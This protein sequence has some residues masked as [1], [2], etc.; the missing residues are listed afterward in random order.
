M[1]CDVEKL[2]M[3]ADG[4][5]S[6]PEAASVRAHLESCT[7]CRDE[8]AAIELMRTQLAALPAPEGEDNWL[9]LAK[10]LP[11]PVRA[12][13]LERWSWR[14][15]ALAPAFALAV[16]AAVVWVQQ[17]RGPSD[18]VLLKEADAEYRGAEA[19]YQ[20]ALAKLDQ[21][22]SH[23]RAEW[24]EARQ[25][26]FD[27]ARAALQAA[28]EQCKKVA[29]AGDIESEQLLFAAYRK[30]IHFYQDELLR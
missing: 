22:A 23:A 7:K 25:K 18:E 3:L 19:Q 6:P 29:Q 12:S 26:E 10:K 13:W 15:W 24:P 20:R 27:A 1:T 8:L 4:D 9:T 2:S 16:V 28:T 21:V 14:R 5:L 30:Q 17:H 11:A